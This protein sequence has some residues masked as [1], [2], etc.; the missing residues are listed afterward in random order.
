MCIAL[1]SSPVITCL[2]LHDND[3]RQVVNGPRTYNGE[4]LA[5]TTQEQTNE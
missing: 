2:L 3:D 5:G 1:R 4:D